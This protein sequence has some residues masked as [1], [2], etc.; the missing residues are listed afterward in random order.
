MAQNRPLSTRGRKFTGLVVSDRMSKTVTVEWEGRR[1]IPKYERYEKKRT[2]VKA[3][4]PDS[5]GA[6]KGDL[7]IIEETR[8]ISKTKNFIVTQI[9]TK[10]AMKQKEEDPTEKKQKPKKKVE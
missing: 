5:I 3:H 1:Y 2:R 4:N 10:N 9:Q 6:V 7:V 8:P